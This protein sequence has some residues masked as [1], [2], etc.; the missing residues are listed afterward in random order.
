MC[1]FEASL[2]DASNEARRCALRWGGTWVVVPHPRVAGKY[3]R[4]A[5]GCVPGIPVAE[6]TSDADEPFRGKR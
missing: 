1:S 4:G 6:F 3:T 5:K 2:E